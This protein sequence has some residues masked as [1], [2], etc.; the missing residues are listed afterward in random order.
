M[1]I[2]SYFSFGIIFV[3]VALAGHG[4]AAS[5]CPADTT[6]LKVKGKIFTQ[7]VS[8]GTS[9]GTAQLKLSNGTSPKCGIMGSGGVGSDGI[10]KFVHQLVCDDKFSVDSPYT[11][12]SETVHSQLTLNSSGTGA[13]HVCNRVDESLPPAFYGTFDE[14]STPISGGGMFQGV[15]D[16][17]IATRGTIN[18]LS[19]LDMEFEG[20]VCLPK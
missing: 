6:P 12:G 17:R 5:M 3:L 4:H 13:F 10:V 7:A 9:L 14:I 16:G 1:F 19:A 11:G 18:C 20:E 2:K 8:S 15:K